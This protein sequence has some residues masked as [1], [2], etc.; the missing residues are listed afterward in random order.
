MTAAGEV[1][2]PVTGLCA[3][4]S[5]P[6][7]VYERYVL[8]RAPAPVPPMITGDLEHK[9]RKNLVED[10]QLVYLKVRDSED[11]RAAY[12]CIGPAVEK[13]A[14]EC[15]RTYGALFPNPRLAAGEL[16]NRLRIEEDARVAAAENLLMDGVDGV[17]LIRQILP[18]K[19]E[20][21]LQSY[22]LGLIGR[23]DAIAESCGQQFPIEYKTGRDSSVIGSRAH[24][25]QVA[26]YCML[27]EEEMESQCRYGEIYY[28]RYFTRKPVLVGPKSKR[29]VL[30]LRAQFLKLC[31]DLPAEVAPILEVSHV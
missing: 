8:R 10:L 1:L 7:E 26:A 27:M 2:V 22:S 25:I 16:V 28:T 24:E 19:V 31:S 29:M 14:L 3:V 18:S 17:D 20:V 6:E 21:A 30:A 13:A 12:Q 23:V 11:L 5:Y 9:S 4:A 15:E